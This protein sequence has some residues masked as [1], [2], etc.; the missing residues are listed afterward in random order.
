MKRRE[1]ILLISVLIALPVGYYL[2][3][4]LFFDRTVDEGFPTAAAPENVF[5][6]PTMPLIATQMMADAMAAE[7]TSMAE[8]MPGGTA[9]MQVLFQG[10]FYDLAHHGSG[11]ATIY[12]LADGSRVLRF[13]DFEVLNGPDLHVYLATQDPVPNT[14]G[15]ELP[16]SIDLGPLKGNLGSQNY[17]LPPDL[18]L[19]S[20]KSVVI[21]CQPF[22]VPFNA[23]QLSPGF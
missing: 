9:E 21:W 12:Q 18:S 5:D 22:R 14:V 8:P 15:V 3:S 20:F 7:A 23:A 10:A 17:P 16:G 19:E 11:T 1:F 2:L 4:P 6:D 13:E